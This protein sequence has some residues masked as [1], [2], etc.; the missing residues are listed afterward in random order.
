M[1][2]QTAHGLV[3]LTSVVLFLSSSY[4]KFREI[5]ISRRQARTP[6]FQVPKAANSNDGD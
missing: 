6:S 1:V 2:T 4:L 3:E 5:C